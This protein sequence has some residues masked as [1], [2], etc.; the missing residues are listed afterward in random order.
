MREIVKALD[1]SAEAIKNYSEE[2]VINYFNNFY[3][4]SFAN[5]QGT[6]NSTNC[7]FNPLDKVVELYKRHV[8]AEKNKVAYL[9]KLLKD[10]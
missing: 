9:E 6:F 2:G 4:T 5:S 8:Q 3:D 10:T 7:T 1:F